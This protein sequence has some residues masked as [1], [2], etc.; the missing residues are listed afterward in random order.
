MLFSASCKY[1]LRA[2]MLLAMRDTKTYVS[3]RELSDE[4]NI[5]F[6]FLTKIFQKMNAANLIDSKKGVN[7]GVKLAKPSHRVTFMDVVNAIDGSCSMDSCAL[8]LPGCGVK[9]SCPMHD[10]WSGIKEGMLEMME[11]VTLAE[12]AK[13]SANE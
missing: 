8:A 2:S 5:S 4:L 7:G 13:N 12:L 3:I 10:Q 11:K 1:G 9:R 6:H